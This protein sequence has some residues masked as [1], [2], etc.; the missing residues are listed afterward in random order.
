M[1]RL[2]I[3]LFGALQERRL[4]DTEGKI[5]TPAVMPFYALGHRVQ[6]ATILRVRWEYVQVTKWCPWV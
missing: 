3:L 1:S 6:C 2:S 5:P 4:L